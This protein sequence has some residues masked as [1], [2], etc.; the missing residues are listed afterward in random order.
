[1]IDQDAGANPDMVAYIIADQLN[2]PR[3]VADQTGKTI[4]QW[5]SINNPFG[6]E[7]PTSATGYMFNLRFPGQ[8]FDD[9]TGLFYNIHRYLDPATGRYRQS[10]PMNLF[11]GQWSTYAYVSGS[12]LTYVD[13]S[14]FRPL[15]P[16]EIG[17]LKPIFN[18]TVNFSIVDIRPGSGI[19]PRAWGP[20]ATSNAVTLENTI[21]FPSSGYK[22]D[23]SESNLTNE[24]WLVHEMT[25][26]YQ[27]QND[28]SY[29]WVKAAKEGL[30][31]DTYGYSLKDHSCF[32]EYGYEQ[33][34]AM[35]A[36]YYSALQ[37][38]LPNLSEY[39]QLL[40]EANLGRKYP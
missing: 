26:V 11:G 1:M 40:N 37:Q 12:P 4:W 32:N 23:F 34:A 18:G 7:A 22:S 31:S 27:Y 30:K 39:E 38:G 28:P 19:D 6:E 20:I 33:Q 9:E 2:T 25:H 24:A 15:T 13:P 35:V 3:V 36:D 14:G 10:D 29:S 21:R 8:Y 17:F 16:G 5:S